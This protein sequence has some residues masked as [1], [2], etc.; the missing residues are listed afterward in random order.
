MP[1]CRRALRLIGSYTLITMRIIAGRFRGRRLLTPRHHRTR[2][3]SSRTREAVF[4][5]LGELDGDVVLDAYAG[6]GALSF[7]A[8]SRGATQVD[9]VECDRSAARAFLQN[10]QTLAVHDRV[11]LFTGDT[12]HLLRSRRLGHYDLVFVD[13]PYDAGI[14]A[15][16]LAALSTS[17]VLKASG[18]VVVEYR[19]AT[20]LRIPDSLFV[21]RRR[22]YGEASI[23][24]LGAPAATKGEL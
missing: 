1:H 9:A 16:T 23:L 7:E 11:H 13:P 8:L 14:C 3:T 19:R 5:M 4:S 18:R 21:F 15:P 20:E 22:T 10:A 12:L 6:S 17:G 2:P 24:I